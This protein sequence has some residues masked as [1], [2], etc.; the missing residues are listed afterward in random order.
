TDSTGKVIGTATTSASG[1]YTF[2]NVPQGTY[3]LLETQ[4]GGFASSTPNALSV[5]VSASG[6]TPASFGE[7]LGALTG[8]VYLA[9]NKNGARGPGEAPL[10]GAPVNL[11]GTDDLGQPVRLSVVSAAD[12]SYAFTDLRPGTYAVTEAQPRGLLLGQGTAGAAGG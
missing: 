7:T 6:A 4:P 10:A 5:T 8:T 12:G 9:A 2:P 3:T 1:S 11:A